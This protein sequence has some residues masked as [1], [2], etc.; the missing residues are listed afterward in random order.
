MSAGAA[1]A[2][3]A[4]A[5][6]GAGAATFAPCGQAT[7]TQCT[8]I[9]VPL[10]RTGAVPGTVS[11]YVQQLAA[12]PAK[13]VVFLLA[14]GPGQSST[15]AFGLTDRNSAQFFQ[16]L[17]PGYTLVTVDVRGTGQSGVL[18]CPRLQTTTTASD[19]EIQAL[20]A[21]CA[22]L[23][24]PNR[25]FYTTRD[26]AA[27]LE[28]VRQALGVDK[29][30]LWGVSYG[31]KLALSYAL[32]FPTHVERLLLDSVLPPEFPDPFE[33]NV[34]HA[35]PDTLRS[36][37]PGSSCRGVTN[38]LGA[39]LVTLANRLQEQPAKG[40]VR[41]P[42]GTRTVTMNGEDLIGLTIDAD[43]DPGLAAELPAAVQAG[44]K[45][46]S[47]PLL[48]LL[49]LDTHLSVEKPEELSFALYA[50][51]VCTD[52][53]FPWTPGSSTSARLAAFD[54]AVAGLAPGS[55]GQFGTWAAHIGSAGFCTL[56]PDP[57]GTP[58]APGPLPDVPVLAV[59]GGLDLRTP[60]AQAAAV[61]ARFPQGHLLV[62]P[63]VGH[64]VIT[65]D[66]SGCAFK[67]VRG[68]LQGA[69]PPSS[70]PRD[71]PFVTPL[72][73][74]PAAP[75]S[76]LG[77]SQSLALARVT[78]HEAEGAWALAFFSTT[79]DVTVAGLSGGTIRVSQQGV[80]TLARYSVV[81]GL[82]LSG[83]LSLDG[84]S[85]PLHFRGTLTVGGARAAHGSVKVD[86]PRVT[87]KLSP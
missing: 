7:D 36:Y 33:A 76:R 70:C 9:D 65:T 34:L 11:L 49:D 84:F 60:A 20:V 2:I 15:K 31:T 56:W 25:A 73:P 46:N 29:V 41:E 59:A 63:G 16:Q 19:A 40:T 48:R 1:L 6:G 72:A 22:S 43:L 51:T 61:A 14:G 81:P 80:A 52:G 66:L 69:T 24:G 30:A 5:P 57:T 62:V 23:I 55:L 32:A 44:L 53:P 38:D 75:S 85:A 79:Q 3:C 37:C 82:E 10:D 83:K 54:A 4:A 64:S 74:F 71:K 50:A 86:G 47:L 67:I 28:A 13:G 17:F 39:D 35:M 87:G 77:A 18:Q 45:R 58:L 8:R 78:E 21:E 68:W 26:Q 42:S 27:D 12:Q